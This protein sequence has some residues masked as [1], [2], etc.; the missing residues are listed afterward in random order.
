MI[1]RIKRKKFRI[2]AFDIESHNDEES[3][4]KN[5]TSMW[6]GCLIDETSKPEDESIY[7]YKME[8]FISH[9][10]KISSLPRN[11]KS[12]P[13]N[14]IAIYIYNLSFEWSFILPVLLEKGY[15][16]NENIDKDSEFCFNSVS[17]KSCSSVWSAT[18]KGNKKGGIIQFIDLAK[19]YGGGLSKVAKSFNLPTQKGIID[20]RK[21]RL[22]D[23]VVTQEEKIYC[24]KDVRIIVDILLKIQESGDKTFFN[25][26]S[27]A[28][29]SMK[30]L[31]AFGWPRSVKP[32]Q[33]FR[34]LYP[35]LDKE[36]SE[37]LRKSVEGG[38][39]YA[40]PKYQFK[41]IKEDIIHI[42]LHQAHPSSAYYNYF[43]TGR[44]TYHTGKPTRFFNKMSCCRIRVSYSSVKLHCCICLIGWDFVDDKEIVVWD[45]IIPLMKECYVDLSI[46][47]L[48]YYEYDAHPLKMR[49]YY[50]YNY[51]KRLEAKAIKDDFLTLYYKLLNN[52]SYG[53]FLERGHEQTFENFINADSCIDSIVHNKDEPPINA[54]YTYLP[55][56]SCIPAYTRR[57]LISTALRFGW[58]NIIYFDTDS[59]FLKKTPET[60]RIWEE[61]IDKKDFLG[62]WGL[63]EI[64]TR[65][66]VS[67]PKRYKAQNEEGEVYIKA[68]GI[69]FNNYIGEQVEKRE[70]RAL[71]LEEREELISKYQLDFDEINI[72][73]SMWKVQRAYRCKGGT[74]I[75]F[76]NKEIKIP[77]KYSPIYARNTKE[78][79]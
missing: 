18:I 9:L 75:E 15:K 27:M 8:D 54:K 41:D 16:Y 50:A 19:I 34:K 57:T 74:L 4:A 56:G 13:I 39:T 67:T 76:Q 21:N 52:S 37:F 30:K 5:E 78:V 47:Y 71:S 72:I 66:Q 46:E 55:V 43:P 6:L 3:I 2:Y 77:E 40:T 36:E 32:Y 17:T 42:D 70:N 28:S 45:F 73:S 22:H 7:F 59:I 12:R 69:N 63:E 44:G 10:E 68:G 38:I 29:Y 48:D 11:R 20:Y 62:G 26:I 14:N 58:E 79:D 31:L 64:I 49:K 25:I 24:F 60:W 35:E 23:Y 61:E 51:N 53:K 65:F 33:E 1:A